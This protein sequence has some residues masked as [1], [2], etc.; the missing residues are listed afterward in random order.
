MIDTDILKASVDLR[1]LIERDTELKH[2]AKTGGGEWAGPCPLPGCSC[3]KDGF[4]VQPY[5]GAGIWLCRRC[6]NGK[7]MDAISYIQMR[8]GLD[9][10]QACDA[11]GGG[12]LPENRRTPS[13]KSRP[14]IPAYAP[15]GEEWQEKAGRI[16]DACSEKLWSPEGER[17]LNY[18]Y[19]RGLSADTINNYRLGFS[20]GYE[21][22]GLW[23]TRGIVIPCVV[24]K[25]YW[26][27]KIRK[28]LPKGS[29]ESK[30]AG[31]KGNRTAAIFGADYLIGEDIALFC[32]GEF[33]AMIADQEILE[34]PCVTIG[35]SAT[36]RLDL[37]TWGIYLLGL[38]DM[39]VCFDA[40]QAGERGA[41]TLEELSERVKRCPL[42]EGSK[43]INDFYL[44]EADLT[45]W[46]F[47]QVEALGDD[48]LIARLNRK[49]SAVIAN[50]RAW[51]LYHGI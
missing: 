41:A 12:N 40:D 36:N 38:R 30:Y 33:D 24:N 32:E 15:P 25:K 3:D 6:T 46:L 7:W 4:R 18:L 9:F 20:P 44:S 16:V 49:R 10:K 8:D 1:A 50:R 27:L 13:P 14:E 31:V 23:V 26:Y 42:P 11:L 43:D 48:D 28:A 19:E 29:K 39:L 2:V 17:A 51:A 35:G 45:T 37:A 47:R 22:E 34:I 21:S 5:N